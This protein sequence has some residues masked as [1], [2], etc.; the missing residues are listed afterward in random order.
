MR[1]G[2]EAR[3]VRVEGLGDDVENVP[4][5]GGGVNRMKNATYERK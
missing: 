2:G 5:A 4:R 1:R 3:D